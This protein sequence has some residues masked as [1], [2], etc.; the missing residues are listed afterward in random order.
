MTEF[1]INALTPEQVEAIKVAGGFSGSFQEGISLG[2]ESSALTPQVRVPI[3]GYGHN[4]RPRVCANNPQE[5]LVNKINID[6]YNKADA[7]RKLAAIEAQEALERERE[8]LQEVTDPRKLQAS[9]QALS[10]KVSRLEKQLKD[11]QATIAKL[12]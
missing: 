10:R 8:L 3:D 4:L 11:T 2:Q 9:L 1:N 12:V 6:K 5:G 7:E